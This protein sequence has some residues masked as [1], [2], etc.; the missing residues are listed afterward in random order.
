MNCLGYCIIASALIGGMLLIMSG[1]NSQIDI[2]FKNSLNDQQL[3][4]Y[5]K[6]YKQR[7]NL[8]YQGAFLGLII[9]ILYI[10]LF[11]FQP[12]KSNICVLIAIIL[13]V[14]YLYYKIMPKDMILN[15]LSNQDQI[16]L[17]TKLY[18]DYNYKSTLGII[19]GIIFII[20]YFF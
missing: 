4:Q 8:F 18:K 1:K 9:S 12:I 16:N 13:G 7:L 20:I 3:L 2:L 11:N 15:Y 17:Y 19:L 10:Y 14:S 6:I 5:H